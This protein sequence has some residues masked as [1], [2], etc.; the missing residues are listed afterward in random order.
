[1]TSSFAPTSKPGG[2][3]L[4]DEGAQTRSSVPRCPGPREEDDHV[5]RETLR[6]PD[7]GTVD[8]DTI[9]LLFSALVWMFAA[10]EPAPGSVSPY[11]PIISALHQAGKELFFL[12]LGAELGEGVSDQPVLHPDQQCGR[13]ADLCYLLA[14]DH[15]AEQVEAQPP[16]LA[17]DVDTEEP[18]RAHLPDELPRISVVPVYGYGERCDLPRRAILAHPLS[19]SCSG[20]TRI[21]AETIVRKIPGA[22]YLSV[23]SSVCLSALAQGPSLGEEGAH[24]RRSAPS[25]GRGPDEHGS[26]RR[27]LLGQL[28]GVASPA[29]L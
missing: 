14:D 5:R 26:G 15:R 8:P 29:R 4:D 20:L 21:S 24:G 1:M 12:I 23:R 16:V 11:A 19:S 9:A 7:L 27:R 3:L 28:S 25:T 13:E 18:M 10:S 2:P 22:L 6:D 17:R